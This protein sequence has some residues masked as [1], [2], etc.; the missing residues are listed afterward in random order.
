MNLIQLEYFRM[1]CH[2]NNNITQAAEKL[3]VSQPCISSALKALE[4]E[5]G[6]KLF[7]RLN[8]RLQ[9]TMEGNKFLLSA[10][11]ILTKAENLSEQMYDFSNKKKILNIGVTTMIGGIALSPLAADFQKTHPD[12]KL[13]ISELLTINIIRFLENDVLDLG[14]ITTKSIPY[15]NTTMIDVIPLYEIEYLFC[16]YTDHP[17]AKEPFVTYDMLKDEPL[18]L[19]KSEN[20]KDTICVSRF[21]EHGLKP[22]NALFYINQID[23]LKSF[24]RKKRASSFLFNSMIWPDTGLVG[25]PFDEHDYCS[26]GIAYKKNRYIPNVVAKFI[27]YAKDY[28]FGI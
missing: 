16:T 25:I 21:A 18:I 4:E 28:G 3:H 19:L 9:L 27:N 15:A 1:V 5:F 24:I 26:I 13:E 10:E 6:V 7:Q 8:N 22:P 20:V 17:L 12:V 2:S 23:T 14:L 11:E